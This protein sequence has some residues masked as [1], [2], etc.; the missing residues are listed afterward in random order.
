MVLFLHPINKLNFF[1]GPI[2]G[3]KISGINIPTLLVSELK[4]DILL[5]GG[6]FGFEGSIFNTGLTIIAIS[7]L[8]R[9][10]DAKEK[11]QQFNIQ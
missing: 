3:Y 4:G 2:L 7:L 6:E 11:G 8:Y 9:I 5:T 1:E 10:Y